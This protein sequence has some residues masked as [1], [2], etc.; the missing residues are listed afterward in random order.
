MNTH[1]PLNKIQQASSEILCI[2]FNQD[3]GCFAIG[4]QNGFHVYTTN[5]I[6][7]RVKRVFTTKSNARENALVLSRTSSG[8][9]PGTGIGHITMLHRTNY[10]ALVGGGKNPKFPTN[11]LIIWDDL[12]QKNS[13]KLELASD[14]LNVL[15]SRTRIIVVLRNQVV[16]YGFTGPQEKFATYDTIDNEF[17]LADLSVNSANSS[18]SPPFDAFGTSSPTSSPSKE[19]KYQTLA[20]PGKQAGQIQLVDVS[21]QG[22]EKNLVSIIKAHK[23]KIRFLSLNRTGT[24]VA[25]ALETGTIIRVHLTQN[26]ALLYEFRRGLDRAVIT[27]MKFSHNDSKLAVLSDKNTLHIFTL[28]EATDS[29]NRRHFLLNISLPVP[30]PQYFKSTWSYCSVNMNQYHDDQVVDEGV[31]GWSGNDSVIVIWKEKRIWER[32]VIVSKADDVGSWDLVRHSWK[33]VET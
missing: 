16:V 28:I 31:I 30:I 29:A 5:P 1:S 20:F 11:R 15:L 2:N 25:S 4:L 24:L 22:Q 10:L 18:P 6:E 26:T 27:S 3:Q 17:G 9:S 13:I 8:P 21:P 19:V 32:Y 23:L 7:S 14:V 33:S 12:K